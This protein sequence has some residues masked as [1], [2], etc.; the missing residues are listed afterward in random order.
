[1]AIGRWCAVNGG[2]RSMP[3]PFWCKDGRRTNLG[4]W[5]SSRRALA[6]VARSYAKGRPRVSGFLKNFR[7][8]GLGLV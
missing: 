6:D 4:A 5:L 3:F 2:E 1:M 8:V 7:L